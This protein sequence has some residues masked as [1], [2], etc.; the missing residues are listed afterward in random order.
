MYIPPAINSQSLSSAPECPA[1]TV[2]GST[3]GN[4][5][6]SLVGITATI[7]CA[8]SHI[9]VGNTTLIC[10]QDGSWSNDI[11][12]CD[13]SKFIIHTSDYWFPFRDFMKNLPVEHPN[14]LL[15]FVP[16]SIDKFSFVLFSGI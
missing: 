12:Q 2:E 4:W 6:T 1:F 10:Q 15:F 3:Q 16:T 14:F 9:L 5:T 11:P 7:E 13:K 8:A